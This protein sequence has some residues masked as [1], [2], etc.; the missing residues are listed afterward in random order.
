MP[1][2]RIKLLSIHFLINGHLSILSYLHTSLVFTW[3][4]SGWGKVR[5]SH[6]W[7]A[8]TGGK[9]CGW[10]LGYEVMYIK[11]V[12]EISID[13]M[14][15]KRL[16]NA[17]SNIID[18]RSYNYVGRNHN[19]SISTSALSVSKWPPEC[20]WTTEKVESK[21]HGSVILMCLSHFQCRVIDKYKNK[22]KQINQYKSNTDRWNVQLTLGNNVVDESHVE[23]EGDEAAEVIDL[24]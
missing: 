1:E 4:Q 16:I 19:L 22:I 11:F 8:N 18:T 21:L 20:D 2:S 14:S 10:K 13:W 6:H 9:V 5:V 7:E 15:S 17:E 24:W 23:A 3:R 12:D